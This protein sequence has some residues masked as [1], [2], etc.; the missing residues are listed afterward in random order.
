[1]TEDSAKLLEKGR[2][3]GVGSRGGWGQVLIFASGQA[4]S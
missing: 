4:R 1:M 3:R 2:S